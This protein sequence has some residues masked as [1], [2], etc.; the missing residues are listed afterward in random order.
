MAAAHGEA[1]KSLDWCGRAQTLLDRT[2]CLKEGV[3]LEGNGW[4]V[5]CWVDPG[6]TSGWCIIA[7][8]PYCLVDPDE[9]ILDNVAHWAAGQILGDELRQIGDALDFYRQWPDAACGTEDFI[10]RKFSM[11]RALLAPVRVNAV[12]GYELLKGSHA[13]AHG[14]RPLFLQM[15]SMRLKVKEVL[16]AT[17]LWLVHDPDDHGRDATAHAVTFLRRCKNSTMSGRRLRHRAWPR[18]FD[19]MGRLR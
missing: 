5:V 3:V 16:P 1:A 19:A 8:S 13:A 15:P 4:C 17:D 14:S 6:E 18:F 11:D 12:L 10:L 7:V 9:R 2:P